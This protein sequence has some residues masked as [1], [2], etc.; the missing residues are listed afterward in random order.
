MARWDVGIVGY[1]RGSRSDLVNAYNEVMSR[2]YPVTRVVEAEPNFKVRCM[3]RVIGGLGVVRR[4]FLLD[5]YGIANEVGTKYGI[6]RDLILRRLF[7]EFMGYLAARGYVSERV[8]MSLDEELSRYIEGGNIER[9]GEGAFLARLISLCTPRSCRSVYGVD[10]EFI[11]ARSDVRD[12][13]IVLAE[14][15][16]L[17]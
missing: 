9:G 2:C 7:G 8:A 16:G 4:A 13:V 17:K 5:P 15:G 6:R 10:I 3:L 14:H 1:V 11:D 12:R